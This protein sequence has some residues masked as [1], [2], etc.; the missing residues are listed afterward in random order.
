MD[1][2]QLVTRALGFTRTAQ[3]LVVDPSSWSVVYDGKIDERLVYGVDK[4]D[5]GQTYLIAA[6]EDVL[7]RRELRSSTSKALGCAITL[8]EAKSI[9]YA[10]TIVPILEKKCLICHFR[11]GT[12][13]SNFISYESIRGWSAMIRETV[14]TMRMPP[15]S[16]DSR[17][18][19]FAGDYSLSAAEKLNLISWID[20]GAPRGSGP[21]PLPKLFERIS[22]AEQSSTFLAESK[23]LGKADIHLK[24]LKS[25]DLPANGRVGYGYVDLGWVPQ[26]ED[27]W[28]RA[29]R[30][31]PSDYN[32]VHHIALLLLPEPVSSYGHVSSRSMLRRGA[33]VKTTLFWTPGR[34]RRPVKFPEGI[35]FRVP[36]NMH[37]GL[38]IHFTTTG[39]P[40]KISVAMDFWKWKS[41]RPASAIEVGSIIA[42][43]FELP[44]NNPD[45]VVER[46][47]TV[48]ENLSIVNFSAHMHLRGQSMTINAHYP[49][50]R[51]ETL[52]SIPIYRFANSRGATLCEPKRIPAGTRLQVLAHYDNSH[53]NPD[54]PNPGKG[55]K[56]GLTTDEDEMFKG[57]F[58]YY[59][60]SPTA[61]SENVIVADPET[62]RRA[63]RRSQRDSKEL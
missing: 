13:P 47:A 58:M 37:L 51:Q 19:C 1:E 30:F 22:S 61:D 38:E 25:F 21:D 34:N 39:K 48:R 49:D 40:E 62:P 14:M 12:D 63:S 4:E 15:W 46:W 8:N 52:F 56:F 54:N 33:G 44:P 10:K 6:I 27:T 57:N 28:F 35:A 42:R 17:K 20:Q 29:V 55:V 43:H 3:A 53:R 2:T 7:T 11:G 23:S 36:R 60:D 31:L 5:P 26:S 50:K 45:V 16:L 24:S 32:A 18:T 59:L 9:D 41:N